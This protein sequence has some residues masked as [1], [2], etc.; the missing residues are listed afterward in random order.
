MA[1][2]QIDHHP[3][4]NRFE[5]LAGRTHLGRLEYELRGN[6][7]VLLHTE[8]EPEAEGRGVGSSLVRTGLDWARDEGRKVDPVCPFV[9]GWLERHPEYTELL[10]EDAGW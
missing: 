1:E 6:V 4:R 3:E 2:I 5:A 9:A 8:V 10:V 7:V